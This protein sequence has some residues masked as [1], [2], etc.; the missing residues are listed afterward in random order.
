MTRKKDCVQSREK[1]V[2]LTTI[3]RKI[4]ALVKTQLF[5]K[6]ERGGLGGCSIVDEITDASILNSNTV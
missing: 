4:V 2:K 1:Q 6:A 3:I 5:V